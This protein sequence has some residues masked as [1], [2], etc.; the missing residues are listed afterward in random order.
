MF[1]IVYMYICKYY[2]SICMNDVYMSWPLK[3]VIVQSVLLNWN[4]IVNQS[5]NFAK[6]PLTSGIDYQQI[7]Q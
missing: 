1:L 5:I 6:L 2:N 4:K 3:I 7:Y